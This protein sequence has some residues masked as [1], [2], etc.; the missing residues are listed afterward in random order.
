[1]RLAPTLALALLA[2]VPARASESPDLARLDGFAQGMT[3]ADAFSGVVL[4]AHGDRVVFERAYGKR[5]ETA[6]DDPL[7]P[8]M[9]FN[10]ASL[11]KLFTTVAVLQQIERGTLTLETPI[12]AVLPHYRSKAARETVTVRHLLMH[13]DGLGGIDEL[14]GAENAANRARLSTHAA[15]V[16]EH[17]DRDPA[18]APGSK[19]AYDN[20]GMVVLGRMVEV[21]SGEDY[22]A[23]I[24][25][26][27][28]APAGM[29]RTDFARCDDP[30]RD[31]AWG[32][33][34]VAGKRV[35]NC[36]TNPMRGFAAG[37]T[38]STARDLLLFVNALNAGKLVG[39]PL[40]AEA[41]R[42]HKEF[43]G[44][45]FFAT[46]YG[47]DKLPRD[48][49]WGHGGSSDGICTDLRHYPRTGETIVT[50]SNRDAPACFPLA[51]FL[52]DEFRARAK[53]R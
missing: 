9:R 16:A 14:F 33:A 13:S 44:L 20:L 29:T 36:A 4:V 15:M 31:A 18:F 41:T 26:R 42:T 19:I 32:Y 24:Q 28:F 2:A 40:L 38:M 45:G 30:A 11:G 5:D 21:L 51:S 43:M 34:T 1:M 39:K 6:E 17:D 22:H 46:D 35:R 47:G 50:L 23:Y 53:K 37:G 48:F 27:V 8:D 12:G 49:R 7:R 3:R 52:H 10:L 25:R